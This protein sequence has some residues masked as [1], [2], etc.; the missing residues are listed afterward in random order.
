MR[1]HEQRIRRANSKT[2]IGNDGVFDGLVYD[3]AHFF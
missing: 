1:I 2:D 3:D